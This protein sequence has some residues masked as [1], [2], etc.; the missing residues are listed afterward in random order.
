M[1]QIGMGLGL[2][3]LLDGAAAA[4]FA[5]HDHEISRFPISLLSGSTQHVRLMSDDEAT[6]AR[7][8]WPEPPAIHFTPVCMTLREPP[9]DIAGVLWEPQ[10][11]TWWV[12]IYGCE[13]P[14]TPSG[15][16]PAGW[17]L[18]S[19][20]DLVNW[21][22]HDRPT[23]VPTTPGN[24]DMWNKHTMCMG[25]LKFLRILGLFKT[26]FPPGAGRRDRQR[27]DRSGHERHAADHE[28][29]PALAWEAR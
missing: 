7:R 6:A 28:Q 15:M 20:T 10:T 23:P 3:L 24:K 1:R 16:G 8:W 18:V 22:L 14:A 25:F 11:N 2:A 9:H 19:S 4:A 17:Q 13:G 21:Q 29:Y 26:N 27:D 12:W 5:P